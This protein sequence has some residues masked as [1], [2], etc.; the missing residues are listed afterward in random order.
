[1]DFRF[2][3]L[4]AVAAVVNVS[5]SEEVVIANEPDASICVWDIYDDSKS[6][7]SH[8]HGVVACAF[9]RSAHQQQS[10]MRHDG[11]SLFSRSSFQHGVFDVADEFTESMCWLGIEL[12]VSWCFWKVPAVP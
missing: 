9:A 2:P 10:S 3:W 8:V 12:C 7:R 5:V 6:G 1:V 4:V 11:S